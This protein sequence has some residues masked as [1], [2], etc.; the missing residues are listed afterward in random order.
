MHMRRVRLTVSGQVQ[1]VFFRAS[2]RDRAQGLGLTGW[3]RNMPDGTVQAEAQGPDDA[4]EELI[5][6]CRRGPRHA[7]VTN[8]RVEDL[9]PVADE[10][11]FEAR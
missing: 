6:F 10:R 8:L 5:I 2:T 9:E 7:T 11:A 1:G 3:V 4:V